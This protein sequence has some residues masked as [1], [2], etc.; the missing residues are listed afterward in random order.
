[1]L[2]YKRLCNVYD[3]EYDRALKESDGNLESAKFYEYRF[4]IPQDYHWRDIRKKTRALGLE[5]QKAL[6]EIENA[7]T[8]CFPRHEWWG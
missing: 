1:M 8:A 6:R 2:F 3:E 7:V 5:F 4:T